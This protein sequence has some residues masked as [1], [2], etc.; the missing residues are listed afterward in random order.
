MCLSFCPSVRPPVR[1]S[2]CL[3]A[4]LSFRF[5]SVFD[6]ACPSAAPTTAWLTGWLAG[7]CLACVLAVGAAT[8][9]CFLLFFFSLLWLSWLLACLRC[10]T[11]ALH[12]RLAPCGRL[13][14]SLRLNNNNSNYILKELSVPCATLRYVELRANTDSPCCPPYVL[15]SLAL[16]KEYIGSLSNAGL[17]GCTMS[18]HFSV[19][20]SVRQLVHPSVYL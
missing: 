19:Y 18:V 7:M 13:L 17:G 4:R 14:S 15:C 5:V 1:P 10:S 16:G 9:F 3:S 2:E 12:V 6:C 8:V 11:V 20:M